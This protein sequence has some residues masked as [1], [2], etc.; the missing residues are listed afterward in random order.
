M[1]KIEALSRERERERVKRLRHIY[2]DIISIE[3]LLVSW[4]QFLRGKRRRKDVI[5][6]FLKLGDNI[7][8][9]HK[10]LKD[11]TYKHGGYYAFKINDPKPRD[12]HK[13]SVRDRLVH[14]AACR[15]LYPY[16][17]KKFIYDSYSCRIKKGT[18][19]AINRF[20]YFGRRVSK[21]NTKTCWILKC[22]IKKFFASI[23]HKILKDILTKYIGD[24]DILWL[25]SQIIDS[26]NTKG[27]NKTGLPLGN[28]TSQLLV[29]IYLNELDCFIKRKLRIKYYIRY[30]D[31]F[32][33]F[34]ENKIWL[35]NQI[36]PIGRFLWNELKLELHKNKVFIKTLSSGIDFL[37]YVNFFTHRILR[38]ATK[39]RMINKINKKSDDLKLCLISKESF[40]QS[41]QSC[42][43]ILKHCKGYKIMRELLNKLL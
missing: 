1:L 15:V 8:L 12:I 31:D 39:R 23:D 41:M 20:L 34:S 37:G 21:N 42:L 27:K 36:E 22:D 35:E 16:F 29:N 4:Q 32:V 40:N 25:L 19:K 26:F 33:I 24:K 6:F 3:N 5:R 38:T 14:H 11:K 28:L 7:I 9:L 17:D 30:A 13:A 10:N 43:G 18:H 2:N